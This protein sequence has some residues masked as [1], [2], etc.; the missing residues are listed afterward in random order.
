METTLEILYDFN[1]SEDDP[2][3]LKCSAGTILV[4]QKEYDDGWSYV[5]NPETRKQGIV[6]TAWMRKVDESFE[7][8]E[9]LETKEDLESKEDIAAS[10]QAS[11]QQEFDYS[12]Y[13]RMEKAGLPEGA[14]INAMNRDGVQIPA[15]FF[16]SKDTDTASKQTEGC[17]KLGQEYE[18]YVRMKKA[19]IP[20]GAIANAME[21]DGVTVPAN[22]F[23]ETEVKDKSTPK[24]RVSTPLFLFSLDFTLLYERTKNT[25][26]MKK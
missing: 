4:L 13:R 12:K 6:P 3:Q 10:C 17:C 18:K 15:D 1:G 7:C 2:W 11:S 16:R 5:R 14:I 25:R 21:R 26:N 20:M 22:F 9:A 24:A 23:G 8:E 19:G